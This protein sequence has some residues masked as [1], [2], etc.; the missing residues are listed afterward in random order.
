MLTSVPQRLVQLR[1]IVVLSDLGH[2]AARPLRYGA[3]LAR[4]YGARLMIAHACHS[5]AFS[6]VEMQEE[7]ERKA[8]FLTSQLGLQDLVDEI[9]VQEPSIGELLDKLQYC[10]PDLLVLATHGRE[11]IRKWLRGSVAEEVFRK[12]QWPVLVLGPRVAETLVFQQEFGRIL[13]ATD[14]SAGSGSALHYAVGIAH[15]HEAQLV[16]LYVE[17]DPSEGFT[18]DKVMA[19]QRLSDWVQAHTL[20]QKELLA[21][22]DYVVQFGNPENKI[23]E[24]AAEQQPDL[25]VLGARGLGAVAG[26]ASHFVGGTSYEVVCSSACPTLVVP[27]SI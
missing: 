27:Q 7:A 20:G 16:N 14:L 19:E 18:F 26:L 6:A 4:W 25:I 12:V 13:Y 23:L 8:R 3:A 22:A 10:S 21:S 15:D 11:G 2:D 24:L 17:T 5:E 1:K 9:S